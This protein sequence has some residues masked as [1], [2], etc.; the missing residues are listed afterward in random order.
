M[1]QLIN[2]LQSFLTANQLAAAIL[3][4]V[5]CKLAC[6]LWCFAL[7]S[8]HGWLE[9]ATRL[10]SQL[11]SSFFTR[12][13]ASIDCVALLPLPAFQQLLLTSV[14]PPLCHSH[15]FHSTAALHAG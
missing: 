3:G 1:T 5:V 2:S 7:L 12:H 15:T 11:L 14:N 8:L 13:P 9:P 6:Q 10:A 4:S